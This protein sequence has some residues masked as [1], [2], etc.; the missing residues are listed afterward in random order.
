MSIRKLKRFVKDA[1][2]YAAMAAPFIPGLG[3]GSLGT[4]IMG[5]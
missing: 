3:I 2:P 4:K 1:L 5:A